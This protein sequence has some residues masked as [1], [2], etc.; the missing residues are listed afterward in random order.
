MENVVEV[1][2]N[3]ADV[4]LSFIIPAC[5]WG[6]NVILPNHEWLGTRKHRTQRFLPNLRLY[7]PFGFLSNS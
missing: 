4:A 7:V 2:E 6:V 1:V 5:G 3:V